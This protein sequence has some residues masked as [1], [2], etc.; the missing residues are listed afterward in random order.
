MHLPSLVIDFGAETSAK[1]APS[2]C[3]V[4]GEAG[5]GGDRNREWLVGLV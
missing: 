4:T 1:W 5:D 2:L 3:V